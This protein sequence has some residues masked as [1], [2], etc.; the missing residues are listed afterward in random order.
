MTINL[1]GIMTEK[2][3]GTGT[4]KGRGIVILI[5]II[6]TSIELQVEIYR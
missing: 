6:G 1:G 2:E 4:G 3:K 5:G